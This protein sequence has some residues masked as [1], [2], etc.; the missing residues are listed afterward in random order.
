MAQ[1]A[2]ITRSRHLTIPYICHFSY[3]MSYN[4]KKTPKTLDC[5]GEGNEALQEFLLS[6]NPKQQHSTA[7]G[8]PSDH[9]PSCPT[10]NYHY[11]L[12]A[13]AVSSLRV[14]SNG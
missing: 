9:L 6:C 8:N 12:L 10:R 7:L 2:N 1:S 11:F 3:F 4:A 14:E 5:L 13:Y